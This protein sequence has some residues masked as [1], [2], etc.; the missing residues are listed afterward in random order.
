MTEI[1]NQVE[2]IQL[3]IRQISKKAQE[4]DDVV[5]FDI[6]QPDFDTP[7]HVKDHARKKLEV[8][9]GYTSTQGKQS[10][11]E[12]IAEEENRK[13]GISGVEPEEVVATCGGMEAIYATYAAYLE[14]EDTVAL[15]NPSWGPYKLIAD[16]HGVNYESTQYFEDGEL[17]DEARDLIRSS[18]MA[19]VTTPDNPTGHV[20]TEAEARQVAEAANQGGTLLLCD[21]VYWQLT[22]G[23]KHITPAQFAEQPVTI[24]SVS[25]N[26]AMTGWRLGWAV[27]DAAE[28]SCISKA[29]RGLVA[30]PPTISQM[31]AEKAIRDPK[32]VKRMRD[33]YEERRDRLEERLDALG[34]SYTDPKGALYVFPHIGEDS[35]NF[36]MDLIDHGVAL[37]PGHSFGQPEHVR[38]CFGTTQPEEIDEAFDRIEEFIDSE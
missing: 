17:R 12:A 4:T 37:V 6:G 27:T 21:E 28:A 24:G 19:V 26:H 33:S 38:I 36:C 11:R 32:H 10:L 13:P 3:S 31:A 30:S 16:V 14:K 18:E 5:R 15:N 1:R 8:K 29:S 7:K 22:Y 2:D 25:K 9:Q 23:Q 35:W 34:W 20:M